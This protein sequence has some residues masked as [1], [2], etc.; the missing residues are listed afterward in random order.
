MHNLAAQNAFPHWEGHLWN[1]PQD[2]L[3]NFQHDIIGLWLLH[4]KYVIHIQVALENSLNYDKNKSLYLI[5][6]SVFSNILV[7]QIYALQLTKDI[8]LKIEFYI[9]LDCIAEVAFSHWDS[10]RVVFQM[11]LWL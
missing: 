2:Q 6:V 11:K 5:I 10:H 1:G 9:R 4:E 8:F 7:T 3:L